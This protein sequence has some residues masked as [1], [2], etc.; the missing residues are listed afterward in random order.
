MPF[1]KMQQEYF[2]KA[3]HRWNVK[4]GATRSGKTY[5]DY[6]TI[7]KRLENTTGK[8][9]NVLIG[10]TQQ[11]L[12]RNIIVPMQRIWGPA[13]VGN[14][15][16]R[17]GSIKI[18]GK[19][20][21][22]LGAD[23]KARVAAIQG[24]S[25]EYC[26]GDEVTTWDQSI[27][28]M[29]KSRLDQPNSTFDGTCNPDN[30]RHWFK[31]FLDS[32]ADI[33]QQAYTIYDNPFLTPAFVESL[34]R[35][36]AGTVYFQRYI[37]G[38]WALAE[39][40]IYKHFSQEKNQY[41]ELDAAIRERCLSYVAIDYGSANP[42]VYLHI[43]YDPQERMI[44]L[45]REFYYDGRK[46]IVQKTDAE[47]G[48]AL[49]EFLQPSQ[50]TAVI[51]DPSALSFR[52]VV[53]NLG[54]RVTEADNDVLNGI[55]DVATLLALGRIKVNAACLHTLDEFGTYAW[56]EKAAMQTGAERPI[57]QYDH[58]MDALRYFVYTVIKMRQML[59]KGG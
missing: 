54:Y 35:E 58:A 29:L 11:T 49:L 37:L 43:L 34:E 38:K 10:H 45:D 1:S 9:L 56:D 24:T 52:L 7:P 13:L 19:R 6:F 50:C 57:K 41:T 15:S 22:A 28:E 53:R 5:M 2:M 26:Y 51:I 3:T 25:I 18:F 27:F 21:Y 59:A 55:Q 31:A 47:Y 36:Y 17:T 16:S 40:L 14:I 12:E 39:G 30:P 4:T 20:C 44:Y 48:Q 23:N 46:E 42:M 32:D 33:F 8:G